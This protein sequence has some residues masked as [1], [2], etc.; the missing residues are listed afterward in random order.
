MVFLFYPMDNHHRDKLINSISGA[1]A[2][3]VCS[4]ALCPLDVIR[5]RIM[6]NHIHDI[7]LFGTGFQMVKKEGIKSLYKGLGTTMIG[8]I[9]NWFG[10]LIFIVLGVSILQLM[11]YLK[12]NFKNLKLEIFYQV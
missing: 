11:N 2:G 4:V 1:F 6:V 12:K 10:F 3:A 5:M 7:G 9:P 8:L